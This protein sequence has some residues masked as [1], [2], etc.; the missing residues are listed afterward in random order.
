MEDVLNLPARPTHAL[1]SGKFKLVTLAVAALLVLFASFGLV[2]R[3]WEQEQPGGDGPERISRRSETSLHEAPNVAA[4]GLQEILAHPDLIPSHEHP[5]LGKQAPG[6]KLADHNGKAWDLRE[7]SDGHPMVLIFYYGIRCVS[8]VR[9]LSDVNGDLRLFQQAGARV[10]AISAD[11]PELTRQRLEQVGA[12]NFPVLSDPGNA[13]ARAYQ[14]FRAD[15]LRHGTFLIDRQV[16]IRWVNVGDAPFR[17]NSALITRL[18]RM[19]DRSPSS[20]EPGASGG[21]RP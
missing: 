1:H 8:C 2:L 11:P 6:F 14:V 16:I 15:H 17:R 5:L 7:L 3:S 20:P 4:T 19:E 13:I 12:F 9:H 21:S 10:V 18:A